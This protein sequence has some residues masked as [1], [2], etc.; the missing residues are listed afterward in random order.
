MFVIKISGIQIIFEC[1]IA[2]LYAIHCKKYDSFKKSLQIH[3]S[4]NVNYLLKLVRGC[5]LFF[6]L[7]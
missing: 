5:F 1:G 3:N 4:Q 2:F 7:F 6:W